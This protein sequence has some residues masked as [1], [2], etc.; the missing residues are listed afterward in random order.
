[1]ESC[2]SHFNL[3]TAAHLPSQYIVKFN[4]CCNTKFTHNSKG[5]GH[6]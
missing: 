6:V 5:R 4:L 1:M 2:V 3:F